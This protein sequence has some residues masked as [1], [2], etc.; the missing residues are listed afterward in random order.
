MQ[1]TRLK[2]P[3]RPVPI[4]GDIQIYDKSFK[5]RHVNVHVNVVIDVSRDRCVVKSPR[6]SFESS[7]VKPSTAPQTPSNFP[8]PSS[9]SNILHPVTHPD[10]GRDVW[11][12]TR[13]STR[14]SAAVELECTRCGTE[15]HMVQY[16]FLPSTPTLILLYHGKHSRINSRSSTASSGIS[17]WHAGSSSSSWLDLKS[18]SSLRAPELVRM[19]GDGWHGI[20]TEESEGKPFKTSTKNCQNL[21]KIL[22]NSGGTS[23]FCLFLVIRKT[24]HIF[25]HFVEKYAKI[26]RGVF[27]D[28]CLFLRCRFPLQ[29]CRGLSNAFL[30]VLRHHYTRRVLP[31]AFIRLPEPEAAAIARCY[32]ALDAL[33][34]NA[35]LSGSSSKRAR[36]RMCA[37]GCPSLDA[38][39]RLHAGK[40][41]EDKTVQQ[42]APYGATTRRS[43]SQC[44][45][46]ASGH[47]Y[48]ERVGTPGAMCELDSRT[49]VGALPSADCA[50]RYYSA[51]HQSPSNLLL[52]YTL[53]DEED[54]P[55][56]GETRWSGRVAPG[57]MVFCRRYDPEQPTSLVGTMCKSSRTQVLWWFAFECPSSD[58]PSPVNYFP[59]VEVEE[60]LG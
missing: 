11:T 35:L 30:A 50:S 46:A 25:R 21:S 23:Y 12:E 22:G 43:R 45:M 42:D 18:V 17:R 31:F 44:I 9:R 2:H 47:Q 54:L 51:F 3:R 40:N 58:P 5:L 56:E 4:A 48:F 37:P 26:A 59:R 14:A 8:K 6:T 15:W 52:L 7:F 49:V 39:Q 41:N 36:E 38:A 53:R 28:A 24:G 10:A 32:E 27:P 1:P 29:Y 57:N 20:E 16:M 19:P 34:D 33:S 60:G 55:L 13:P